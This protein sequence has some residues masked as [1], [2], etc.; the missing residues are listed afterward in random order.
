M[1]FTVSPD[2]HE[3]RDVVE[4]VGVPGAEREL[5]GGAHTMLTRPPPG[6]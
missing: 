4:D 6:G 2:K 1:V 5:R 3:E